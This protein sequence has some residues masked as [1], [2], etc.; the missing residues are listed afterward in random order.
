MGGERLFEIDNII[1]VIRILISLDCEIKD[2][3]ILIVMVE[4]GGYG[5]NVV[6]RFFFYCIIDVKVVDK[7][8]NFFI[9]LI[10]IY[11]VSVW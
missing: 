9:F 11:F 7:N 5:R 10:R 3:Y 4:D 1:G 2:C 6:E 8:D